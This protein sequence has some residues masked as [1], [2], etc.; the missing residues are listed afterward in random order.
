MKE[1]AGLKT[2]TLLIRWLKLLERSKYTDW[3]WNRWEADWI[4]LSFWFMLGRH[5]GPLLAKWDTSCFPI[6]SPSSDDRFWRTVGFHHAPED[7]ELRCC[8]DETRLRSYEK[9]EQITK[10][11]GPQGTWEKAKRYMYT[12]KYNNNSMQIKRISNRIKKKNNNL[13][14]CEKLDKRNVLFVFI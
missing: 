1:S 9:S 14:L 2:W 3:V 12:L 10:E 6:M 4:L 7:V 11:R 5:V 13:E 8:D